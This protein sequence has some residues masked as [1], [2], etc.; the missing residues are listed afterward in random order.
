MALGPNSLVFPLLSMAIPVIAS[1]VAILIAC[2]VMFVRVV[3]VAGVINPT[4][5]AELY[6]PMLTMF[7]TT[8]LIAGMI[9]RHDSN[10]PISDQVK[11]KNPLELAPALWFGALLAAVAL[12][13]SSLPSSPKYKDE[14]ADETR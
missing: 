2:G 10:D 7:A 13:V 11:P 9:F 14:D 1:P 12:S 6:L 5:V 8:L 4:L 3:L